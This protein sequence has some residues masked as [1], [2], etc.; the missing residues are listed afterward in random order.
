MMDDI[1]HALSKP[2]KAADGGGGYMDVAIVTLVCPVKKFIK[3]TY[4]LQ[5]RVKEAHVQQLEMYASIN[6]IR[7]KLKI[8]SAVDEPEK[9]AKE[10][11]EE[12]ANEWKAMLET[13][14]SSKVNIEEVFDEFERLALLGAV[15]IDGE[16][17]KEKNWNDLEY[18]DQEALMAKYLHFFINT[19]VGN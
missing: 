1:T 7:E 4:T 18:E 8:E 10:K 17:I 19:L 14:K 16:I 3:K 9:T 11:K 2:I 6:D 13:L 15:K 12:E 5:Q